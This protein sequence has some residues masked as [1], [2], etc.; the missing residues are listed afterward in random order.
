MQQTFLTK[1]L[2]DK[3]LIGIRTKSQDLGESIIG[4]IIEVEDSF[5][6]INE[7]DK[8][9]S[10]IGNT[11]IETEEIINIDIDDRYQRRL[12]FIHDNLTTFN[13][14]NRITVWKEGAKLLPY[15]KSLIENKTIVTFYFNDDDYATG[16]VIRLDG[17]KIIID[18]IGSEG[19]DDGLS[20]HYVNNLIGLRY[21]SLEEQKIK[22]LYENR[23]LFY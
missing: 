15:L 9:G 13:I 14:N 16:I 8:Y 10:F 12:K 4:F 19:D 18:N 3:S 23:S 22:L 21:N 7:I 17:S 11:T 20:C 2:K 5:F 1:A 6:I